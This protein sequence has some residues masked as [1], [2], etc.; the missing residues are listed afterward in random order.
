MSHHEKQEIIH[1]HFSAMLAAPPS[2]TKD[3][4]WDNLTFPAV[5]LES[6][7]TPFTEAEI[8]NAIKQLPS[9]KSPGPDGFTG[10]FFKRCWPI[11]KPDVVAAVNAFYNNRCNDLNLLNKATIVLIP[12][13]EGAEIIQDF[14]PIS[15][16]HAIAK[17]ITKILALRLAPLM[18]DL[19]SHCQSAF[20]KGRSI[21]DNFM[22]VRNLA[23]RFHRN[24]TP[25]LLMKLDISK[26]FDSVRWDYL[27]TLLQK[28]GFPTRWTNWITSILATS[29]S[30]VLL[31]GIPLD[32]IPHDR[33]VR[34]GDPL[35]LPLFILAVD[36]LPRLLSIA[37][38]RGLL[39]KL[40]GRA[41]RFRA[42]L[43]ADDAAI[44][45]R[46]DCTDISNLAQLLHNFG[47]ASGLIT[48]LTKTSV[49][50]I[51]CEGIDLQTLLTDL[52]V[53]RSAFPIRYLG[54]P[55]ST[56]R[57]RRVDFQPLIDKTA[58]KLS[59][60]HGRNLTQARRATLTKLV[61]TAQ[62]VYSLT[63]LKP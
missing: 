6:L 22:Y 46:P 50:P 23:R 12:K 36:P 54:L 1:A 58:S 34:Q 15:L 48:N 24:K 4:R 53:K 49:T 44:F 40:R 61:L 27:I 35:S 47:E 17:I 2:R 57:L 21:H 51:S 41:A 38:A 25:A 28:R 7:D 33:G 60:W 42:S 3:L 31:N 30:R 62:P 11:I 5:E 56:T 13:K 43:Y 8:L 18:N 20:I 19:T 32:P 10:L 26:A 29:T 16:I 39:S 37:T 55:L 59:I 9:D 63:A 45:I 52:P 14:R